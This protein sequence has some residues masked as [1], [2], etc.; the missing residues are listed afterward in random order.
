MSSGCLAQR[1]GSQ[2]CSVLPAR[3]NASRPTSVLRLLGHCCDP[4]QPGVGSQQALELSGH[5]DTV[6][7]EGKAF[8]GTGQTFGQGNHTTC[9]TKSVELEACVP[10]LCAMSLLVCAVT[11]DCQR[12]ETVHVTLDRWASRLMRENGFISDGMMTCFF[13]F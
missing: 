4:C 10:E 6:R 3:D 1:A 5:T 7:S 11:T 12:T 13:F 9:N 8:K 2:L